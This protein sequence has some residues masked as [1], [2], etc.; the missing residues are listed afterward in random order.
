MLLRVHFDTTTEAEQLRQILT[1]QL[2]TRLK[3]NCL[4]LHYG[5]DQNESGQRH[6]T[7]PIRHNK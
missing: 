7:F 3:F 6:L 1:K 2:D 4:R 5:S